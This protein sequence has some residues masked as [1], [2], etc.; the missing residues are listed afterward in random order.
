MGKDEEEGAAPPSETQRDV[1]QPLL[2]GDAGEGAVRTNTSFPTCRARDLGSH[3]PAAHHQGLAYLGW[4][5]EDAAA[6]GL[7]AVSVFVSLARGAQGSTT[8]GWDAKGAARGSVA[9]VLEL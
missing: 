9:L 3:S 1:L 4:G 5:L 7:G 6:G 2:Y 8:M